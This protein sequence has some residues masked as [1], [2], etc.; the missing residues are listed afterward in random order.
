[1][2]Q[3]LWAIRNGIP[4]S[5][6]M[7]RDEWTAKYHR[8]PKLSIVD[9]RE[10][11]AELTADGMSQRETAAVLGVSAA[12]VNQDINADDES[13]F[14]S[15]QQQHAAEPA[16]AV[17]VLHLEQHEPAPV[18][19]IPSVEPTPEPAPKKAH[20]SHNSG[21]NEWY[22]PAEYIEAAVS[23]M[24]TDMFVFNHD[25][26]LWIEAKTKTVF[27]WYRISRQ[28]ETGI[29]L[30]H[31][32]DYL[33]IDDSTQ[34]PV[35]LIFLHTQA[36]PDARDVPYCPASCPTGLFDHK[37]SVLRNRESHCSDRHGT[38]GMVYWGV[39]SLHKLAEL[40]EVPA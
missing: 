23:V 33:R 16:R 6:G 12:T 36:Q 32:R 24:A 40:A 21:D 30:R 26:A 11:V 1:M 25:S 27:S 35:W 13:V 37:L 31:Y 39:E 4:E 15:E 14:N 29:D 9:R 10:A 17:P 8:P 7:T 28:W 3:Y 20:V 34:W 19:E 38:S 22:T 18:W 5:L 2:R